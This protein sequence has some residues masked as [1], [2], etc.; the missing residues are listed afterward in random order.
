MLNS[1]FRAPV[2]KLRGVQVQSQAA[3]RDDAQGSTLS[4]TVGHSLFLCIVNSDSRSIFH[5]FNG[6]INESFKNIMKYLQ[7]HPVFALLAKLEMIFE[8][9]SCTYV[10]PCQPV[11]GDSLCW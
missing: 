7:L 9:E 4:G 11:F 8:G 5:H 10:H 6:E 1:G 2:S 3:G